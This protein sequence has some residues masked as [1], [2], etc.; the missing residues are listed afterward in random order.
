[1]T[2]PGRINYIPGSIE[3]EE[4]EHLQQIG[5]STIDFQQ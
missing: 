4:I 1:L 5:L 2:P 3:E